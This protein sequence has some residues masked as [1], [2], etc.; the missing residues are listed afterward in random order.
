VG[1]ELGDMLLYC[2]KL[3]TKLEAGVISLCRRSKLLSG[4]LDF[5]KGTFL[6]AG[7]RIV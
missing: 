1:M 3:G 5:A 6:Y 4:I 7:I 2:G